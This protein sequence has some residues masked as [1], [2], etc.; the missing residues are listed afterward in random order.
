MF[1]TPLIAITDKFLI[2]FPVS[3]YCD[4]VY[5]F[6][7]SIKC[8]CRVPDTASLDKQYKKP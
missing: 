6:C 8:M 1:R 5:Q 3:Q 2:V 4:H 7:V